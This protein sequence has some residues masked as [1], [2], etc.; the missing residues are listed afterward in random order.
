MPY[1]DAPFYRSDNTFQTYLNLAEQYRPML[2]DARS[3]TEKLEAFEFITD[4]EV[5]DTPLIRARNTE[6][7]TGINQLFLKFEGGNPSGTQK[8]RIA[9]AQ[10]LDALR[11]GYP[12]IALATCGNYGAACAL[13]ARIAQLSCFVFIPEKYHAARTNEITL[14]GATVM[15]VQG[16]Y[17]HAVEEARLFAAKADLYDAN[18]GG[19]NTPIQ[20]NAYARIAFEIYDELRDAPAIVAAPVSNGSVLAGIYK[21]FL[22]LYHRGKTS[23][24]PAMVAGSAQGQNPIINAFLR[25][26]NACEDLSPQQIHET[27]TNEPLI[28]WHAL[29]GNLALNAIQNSRGWATNVSDK[30]L[31]SLAKMLK[32]KDG[33]SVLP[34]ATA[35]LAALLQHPGADKRQH[36]RFVAIITAKK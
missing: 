29:D 30:Q 27:P 21:G 6:R 8:D 12:G 5:G 36:D 2:H 4:K 35:G 3:T 32:D 34:A 22:S 31:L 17:E 20:L 13:A 33:I 24:I 15:P 25:H 10:C 1:G 19:S 26:K 9:F 23:R 11:R 7:E 16:D 28:S 18:P 14:L